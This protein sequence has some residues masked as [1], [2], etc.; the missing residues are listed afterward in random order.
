MKALGLGIEYFPAPP[1]P[2]RR[3]DDSP[4]E[5]QALVRAAEEAQLET[6]GAMPPF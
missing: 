6:L 3:P 5:I 2:E 4:P 1:Y